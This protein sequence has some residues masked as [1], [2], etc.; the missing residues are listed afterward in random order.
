MSSDNPLKNIYNAYRV[1]NDCFK[2]ARRAIA[3][4]E[5][6]GYLLSRTNFV[7]ATLDE[8]TTGLEG[9]VNQASD[10]AILALFATFE[11]WLIEHLQCA[12]GLIGTGHPNGYSKKLA[13]KFEVAVERWRIEEILDL[14]DIEVDTQLITRAKQIKKYRD[15]IAHRNPQKSTPANATPEVAF[16]VLTDLIDQIR[17]AHKSPTLQSAPQWNMTVAD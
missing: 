16:E 8:A 15:W 12:K 14:F 2:V 17:K 13:D 11:R 1:A 3:K 7:G 9:A 4:A 6:N 5:E 10:L